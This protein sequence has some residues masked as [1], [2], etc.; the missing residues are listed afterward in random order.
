MYNNSQVTGSG[1]TYRNR[2]M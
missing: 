2:R 1:D